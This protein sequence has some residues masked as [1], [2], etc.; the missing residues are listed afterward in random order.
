MSKNKSLYVVDENGEILDTLESMSSYTKL[1][2]G[3]KVIRKGAIKYLK[4][5]F[6]IKYHFIKVNPI[7][8]DEIANKYI[9]DLRNRAVVEKKF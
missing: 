9:R 4:D 2:Y 6:D 5:S 8:Y 7:I 1:D 3:D